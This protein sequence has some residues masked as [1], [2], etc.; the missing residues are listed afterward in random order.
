MRTYELISQ[1]HDLGFRIED[2]ADF[3]LQEY[4]RWDVSE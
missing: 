4:E 3:D 1:V 2:D